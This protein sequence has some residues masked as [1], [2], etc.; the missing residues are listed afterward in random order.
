MSKSQNSAEAMI[1]IADMQ[2][3]PHTAD[4]AVALWSVKTKLREYDA[5]AAKFGARWTAH[6]LRVATRNLESVLN[7]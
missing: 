6:D 4:V 5:R 1:I 7:R 3:Q 2:P